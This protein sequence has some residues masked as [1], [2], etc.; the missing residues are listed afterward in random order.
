MFTVFDHSHQEAFSTPGRVV[1]DPAVHENWPANTLVL[2][3]PMFP[4]LYNFVT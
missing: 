2:S 4:D 1:I 3:A